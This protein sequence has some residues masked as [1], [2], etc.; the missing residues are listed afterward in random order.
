MTSD[1]W[2]GY[3]SL[4]DDEAVKKRMQEIED[5]M[6]RANDKRLNQAQNLGDKQNIYQFKLQQTLDKKK[7]QLEKKELDVMNRVIVKH[8]NK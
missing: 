1:A 8:H 7:E 2:Y 3:D 6:Q 4:D 5:R